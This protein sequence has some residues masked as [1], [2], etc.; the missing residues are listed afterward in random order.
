MKIALVHDWLTRLG[1][2]ERVLLALHKIFPEAPV[3]TLFCDKKFIFQYLPDTEVK[4]SYLQQIPNIKKAHPWFKFLMPSA[5]ESFDFSGFDL[6]ISSSHEFSHG[7]LVKPRTKHLS[8]YHSPSRII[9]D[10][11]H[12]F[13]RDFKERGR[14]E[15]KT[16]LIKCGQHFLRL[17]DCGAGQRPDVMVANSKHIAERIKKYYRREAKVIYPPVEVQEVQNENVSS[18]KFQNYFLMVNQLYPH[19]NVDLAVK[20]FKLLNLNLVVVGEG[21]EKKRLKKIVGNSEN[22]RLLGFVSDEDASFYYQNCLGY[23]ICNEEDFGISPV[24]AM[25]FGKPV[26]AYRSGGAK[27]YVIEGQTGEFFETLEPSALADKIEF[28]NDR[29]KN[30]YYHSVAIK[31]HSEKFGFERFKK[32]ILD[33]IKNL[34]YT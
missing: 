30:S 11:A 19:K 24:E 27:E 2:A 20:A 4:T 33:L 13:V 16:S 17:W 14:G 26:L 32:E 34:D 29:I 23:L 1:G 12:E 18:F 31:E 10:R 28:F 25:S 8:F 15:F 5:I 6:V 21:P 3:Y 9:W 7:I 22:I